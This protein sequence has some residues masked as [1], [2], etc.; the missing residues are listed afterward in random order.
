MDDLG[1]IGA[2]LAEPWNFPAG[3]APVPEQLDHSAGLPGGAQEITFLAT[4]TLSGIAFWVAPESGGYCCSQT[5]VSVHEDNGG[6]IGATLATSNAVTLS[7]GQSDGEGVY[8][9]SM[10][11]TLPAGA[12]WFEIDTGP[13]HTTNG[14]SILGSSGDVYSGGEWSTSPGQDAYFR[15][16]E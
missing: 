6:S 7:Q 14:T 1:N 3:Y 13:S 15:I 4:T 12:Y 9:F 8:G 16:Q 5:F 11:L 2:P 10:P